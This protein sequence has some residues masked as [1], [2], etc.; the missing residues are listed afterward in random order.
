MVSWNDA[1]E[2]KDSVARDALVIPNNSRSKRAGSLPSSTSLRF[3]IFTCEY[4]T[5]SPGKNS[6]SPAKVIVH[7]RSI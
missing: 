5:V 4:S 6:E 2:M 3:A 7:L 1:A